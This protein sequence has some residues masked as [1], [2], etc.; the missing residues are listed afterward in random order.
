MP[1]VPHYLEQYQLVSA[2]YAV[3][4]A[5]IVAGVVGRTGITTE[6]AEPAVFAALDYIAL[7]TGVAVLELPAND[8]LLEVGTELLAARIYQDTPN[9]GGETNQIDPTFQGVYTPARLYS[10]LDSYWLHLAV[11]FGVA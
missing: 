3:D 10:H 9:L 1:S 7:D 8:V 4:I 11:N 2:A 6:Q 5:A